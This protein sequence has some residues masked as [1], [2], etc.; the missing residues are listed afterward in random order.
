MNELLNTWI[1][2]GNLWDAQT[3]H[4]KA[5]CG[6]VPGSSSTSK[7]V[8]RSAEC[9][10]TRKD[11]CI[12]WLPYACSLHICT[13][14]CEKVSSASALWPRL[15]SDR[16]GRRNMC[17]SPRLSLKIRVSFFFFFFLLCSV[18]LTSFLRP[19]VTSDKSCA[20]HGT[21]NTGETNRKYHADTPLKT[22][23]Q[24]LCVASVAC[25]WFWG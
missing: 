10:K 1:Q 3:F 23:P 4:N 24:R 21:V 8:G 20:Q 22:S 18:G 6:S 7:S 17:A 13:C 16:W 14:G 19:P 11:R 15:L 5:M 12:L 2:S 25:F 9:T